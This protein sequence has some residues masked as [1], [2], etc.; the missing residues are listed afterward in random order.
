MEKEIQKKQRAEKFE[1]EADGELVARVMCDPFHVPRLARMA[2]PTQTAALGR[3][4]SPTA[5]LFLALCT[6]Q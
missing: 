2:A 3:S 4:D 6:P 5:P 1:K